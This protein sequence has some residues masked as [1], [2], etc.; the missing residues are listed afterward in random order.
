MREVV[1]VNC[2]LN[3]LAIQSGQDD[4]D[5]TAFSLSHSLSRISCI[6]FELK[7][8]QDGATRFNLLAKVKWQLVLVFSHDIVVLLRR[9]EKQIYIARQRLMSLN[10]ASVTLNLKRG[11]FSTNC[12]DYVG[13][14]ICPGLLE[15]SSQA[16]FTV[17]RLEHPVVLTELRSFLAFCYIFSQILSSILV[18]QPR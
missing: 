7:S 17:H 1:D 2:K 5:S 6:M 13:P 18:W 15:G 16:V 9:P 12:I 14:I 10:N 8:P 3:S 11:E 4:M